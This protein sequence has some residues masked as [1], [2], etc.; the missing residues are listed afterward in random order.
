MLENKEIIQIAKRIATA[1]LSSQ[2]FTSI[3]SSTGV[4]SAGQEA[5]RITITIPPG[6]ES[7]ITGDAALN[8]LVQMQDSLREAGEDRFPII[9]YAT[10]KELAESGDS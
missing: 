7:K 4:D 2:N 3:A 9:E 1:N 8:T 10:T 6:A 5:L